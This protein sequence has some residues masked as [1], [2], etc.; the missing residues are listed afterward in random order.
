MEKFFLILLFFGTT[1]LTQAQSDISRISLDLGYITGYQ[2][3]IGDTN[4]FQFAPE[5]KIGGKLVKKYFEWDFG[6]S[7]WD[8]GIDSLLNVSDAATYS[9]SST[10]LG[11]HLSYFPPDAFVPVHFRTN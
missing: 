9:Y 3:T 8:D 1:I 10:I 7:Y 2:I 6:I 11:L 5:L 4:D